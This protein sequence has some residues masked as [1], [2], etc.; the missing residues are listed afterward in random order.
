MRPLPLSPGPLAVLEGFWLIALS[1]PTALSST[2]ARQVLGRRMSRGFHDAGA[3]GAQEG[4][5][6]VPIPIPISGL[7]LPQVR[8]PTVREGTV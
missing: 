5:V 3:P 6:S 4:G 2:P 8:W 7:P 1:H